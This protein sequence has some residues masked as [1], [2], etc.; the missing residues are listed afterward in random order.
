MIRRII[1]KCGGGEKCFY[2]NSVNAFL[3]HAF[4]KFQGNQSH[5][6][7]IHIYSFSIYYE[8]YPYEVSIL[9]IEQN[10]FGIFHICVVVCLRELLL[11]AI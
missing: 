8:N 4:S 10:I 2:F 3:V 1:Y 9:S 11:H 6:H 5:F 7:I